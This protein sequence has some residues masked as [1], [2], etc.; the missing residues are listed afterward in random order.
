MHEFAPEEAR[1]IDTTGRLH[2]LAFTEAV[3]AVSPRAQSSQSQSF[4][5]T[6]S[7]ELGSNATKTSVA[8]NLTTASAVSQQSITRQDPG[9]GTTASGPSSG[10]S[11]YGL[12]ASLP[13]V[14]PAISA[15][16]AAP[17]GNPSPTSASSASSPSSSQSQAS[18]DQAYWAAQP[19]AVQQ[20]Q[21]ITDPMER[22]DVA[23]Q[24]AQEGYS[25]DVPIMVWGWD[26]QTTTD[27]R[28]SMGYT[29]VP[30]AQQK[31]VEVAPGVTY[32]G[33]TYNPNNPPAGSI[34]V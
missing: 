23:S 8:M 27:A 26:P 21:Y 6:L 34:T 28:Q 11:L 15:P 25:I 19:P 16:V 3:I 32:N 12:V 9:A 24:L 33:S 18:F 17:E 2:P 13:T 10:P 1:M 14:S 22:Q 20:L 5:R 31:P 30:S 4:A 29:W 7:E